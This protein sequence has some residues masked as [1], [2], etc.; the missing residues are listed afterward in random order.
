MIAWSRC[1]PLAHM[2]LVGMGQGDRRWVMVVGSNGSG[3]AGV[4][5]GIAV[6]FPGTEIL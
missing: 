2:A 5:S 3:K 4:D 1:S 6:S